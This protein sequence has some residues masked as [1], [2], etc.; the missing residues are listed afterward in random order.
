MNFARLKYIIAYVCIAA[1]ITAATFA[2][3]YRSTLNQLSQTGAVRIEQARDRLLGQLAS[4]RQLPNYLA[5]HPIVKTVLQDRTTSATASEFLL[6]TALISGADNIFVLDQTGAT[7]ASS[8]SDTVHNFIGNNY[9]FKPHVRAAMNGRLGFYHALESSDNSRDFYIARG[10]SLPQTPHAGAVVIQLDVAA[11][12]FE[13]RV[14]EEVLAFFDTYGVAFVTNRQSLALLR[15][16]PDQN[17]PVDTR[18]YAQHT[19]QPF[20]KHTKK[21][22]FGHT[23]WQ[24]KNTDELPAQALVISKFIPQIEMTARIFMDT[25]NAKS[26]ARIQALLVAAILAVLGLGM[27]VL[28]QRRQRLADLLAIKE[29]AN[30]R[31][32]ARV[33]KR[34]AQL[35]N[36]QHQ[37]IQAGKLTAMGQ[38]SAGISHELN[39]PLAAIQNFAES[40]GKL[41]DRGRNDDARDNFNLIIQQIDR[42]SRI[43]RSLRAFA[44]KEKETVEPVDLQSIINESINLATVR[45]EQEN[46]T[47]IRQGLEKPVFVMGGQVRLQQ[48][49]INLITNAID[50]MAGQPDKKITLDL[51]QS[52]DAIHLIIQDTGPGFTDA[53]RVF[54]PFYSTKEI[55][56]S[57]GMGL[58]L[59]ISYGIVG[60][61]GGDI[62]CRNHPS[63]GAE[64]TV[65]LKP[66]PTGGQ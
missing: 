7:I 63:G 3:S 18:R 20:F 1:L 36:T 46:V 49:V 4:F 65:T 57:K 48:V 47:I 9:A 6:N 12:E 8:N 17:T 60:S 66:A 52:K 64:F 38:M 37:L 26:T 16:T 51:K 29:T 34:T 28:L 33:E 53:A 54:E 42:M 61:F 40:G 30:A 19:L 50:A 62:T 13:W 15:E 11:L 23:L 58:G 2:L 21:Q 24:F 35:R 5:K 41:I 10:V 22:I 55:G 43:I 45:C 14:D 44:R 31:L 25:Q 32:E 27:W 59:S 56:A 39:Q